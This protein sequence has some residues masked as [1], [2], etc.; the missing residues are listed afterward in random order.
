M[1]CWPDSI[2]EG[3]DPGASRAVGSTGSA[4]TV[5][6]TLPVTSNL[7]SIGMSVAQRAG[8]VVGRG[9]QG[10]RAETESE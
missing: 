10:R 4:I 7:P 9:T 5:T 3:F 1:S 2:E 6:T 8:G